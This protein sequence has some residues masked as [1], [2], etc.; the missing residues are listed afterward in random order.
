MRRGLGNL[1]LVLLLVGFMT[2]GS[3][4]EKKAEKKDEKK[5]DTQKE[6]T[7]A[8]EKAR[9]PGT[10]LLGRIVKIDDTE[11]TVS[12]EITLKIPQVNA[13]AI[14]RS[15]QIQQQLAQARAKGDI[16]QVRNLIN[17]L[18][19][20]QQ[21]TFKDEKKTIEFEMAEDLKVR[22]MILPAEFTDKGKPRRLTDKEKRDLKGPDPKLKGY[23]AEF[24][25]LQTEQI[26]EVFVVPVKPV[27]GSRTKVASTAKSKSKADAKAES[28]T[29]GEKGESSDEEEAPLP[30]A[31]MI[32]ILSEPA[33]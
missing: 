30:K 11:E 10:P 4:Q 32:V 19:N 18:N 16:G 33:K 28:K 20:Q 15:A 21:V 22:T 12:V 25:N 6:M 26:V 17:E 27:P 24:S 23:V 8:I 3:A 31:S 2:V 13:G 1:S 9:K 5:S 14:Q 7:K 29:K